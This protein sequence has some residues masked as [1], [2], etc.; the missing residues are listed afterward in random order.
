MIKQ[1]KLAKYLKRLIFFK[2]L[3]KIFQREIFYKIKLMNQ[4]E[5]S[6][7]FNNLN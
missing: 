5:I 6:L 2:M 3:Y 1:I 4:K 7:K